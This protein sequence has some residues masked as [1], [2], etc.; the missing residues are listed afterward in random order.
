MLQQSITQYAS[1]REIL[2]CSLEKVQA[3]S[4][5]EDLGLDR[6]TCS[7][8]PL[9]LRTRT[10]IDRQLKVRS[11]SVL[12][13]LL[14][15]S[16]ADVRRHALLMLGRANGKA[17]V[18]EPP[19]PDDIEYFNET[20]KRGPS[21][22]F[23]KLRIDITGPVRSAWNRKAAHRFRK[24]FQKAQ[25]YSCWP[26][27]DIEEAFLRHVETIRSHY[28][29]QNGSIPTDGAD[30][31]RA[32]A[33]RRSRLKTV[34]T[35]CFFIAIHYVTSP[36][37]ARTRIAICHAVPE[38]NAFAK[39][40]DQLAAGGMSG[41]ESDNP[42]G[43]QAREH[44]RFFVVPPAWRSSEVTPWLQVIDSAHLDGRFSESGRASRGNW[45]RHRIR[46]SRT[47]HTRPPVI[48]LPRNFYDEEW[49]GHLSQTELEALEM[50]E[51][52][53]LEHDPNLVE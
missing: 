21:K 52:V 40:V 22:Q 27:E 53:S 1:F 18:P 6:P 20:G 34:R 9:R 33:A 13:P 31:R 2:R 44:R 4:E 51:E 45:V 48:G 3:Y 38:L 24:T 16:Q 5:P 14:H 35:V 39:Y 7:P 49:L 23:G 42:E 10:K 11:C 15:E 26:K 28:R 47:D 43:R 50:Q 41:D 46:S 17:P 36:Q 29:E 37:L 19:S 8:R 32:R 30:S 25:L 12:A